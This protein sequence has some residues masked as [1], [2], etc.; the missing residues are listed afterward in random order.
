MRSQSGD[1]E[2]DQTQGIGNEIKLRG[3]GTRSNS[4]DWE[5]DQTQGIGNEI[6]LRGLGTRSIAYY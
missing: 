1:W 3:L 6:K 2:R 4:G 5:R